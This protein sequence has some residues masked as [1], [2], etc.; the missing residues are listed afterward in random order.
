MNIEV[1]ISLVLVGA[2][3]IGGIVMNIKIEK[4]EKMNKLEEKKNK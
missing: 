3:L 1:V 2:L 4:L